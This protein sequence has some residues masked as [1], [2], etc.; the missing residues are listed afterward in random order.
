MA[1][2][3]KKRYQIWL[4]EAYVDSV[5][6]VLAKGKYKGGL[7][8][9]LDDCLKNAHETLIESGVVDSRRPVTAAKLIRLFIRGI[10][11]E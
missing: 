3:G 6:S 5:R 2:P 8:G 4:T 11:K 7:S 9:Y 10:R 1:V